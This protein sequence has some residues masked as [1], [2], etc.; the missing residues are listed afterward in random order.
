MTPDIV[1]DIGNS[2]MK[3]GRVTDGKVAEMVS[4][5]HDDPLAWKRQ[6]ELWDGRA[7]RWAIATVAPEQFVR[8]RDWLTSRKPDTIILENE[9]ALSVSSRHGFT[10]AVKQ[11]DRIG[12][13]RLLTAIAAR[14]RTIPGSTTVA[15]SVGTAMTVDF[16]KED[17]THVGGAILPGPYLMAKSLRDHTAKLPHIEID[18]VIPV[19]VWGAN[20][21]DAIDLGIASAI[22]GAAEHLVWDWVAYSKSLPCVFVTGGDAGYFR[23]YEFT[24]D[25]RKLEIDP[26]LTLEGIRIVAEWLG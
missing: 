26:M 9:M 12:I 2:R 3:W 25:I 18:P 10:T 5:P 20:T 1:V 6:V 24:A 8:F 16:V 23:N 7:E 13:D 11:I 15:I 19:R 4:L 21:K 17:G 22:L 14:S